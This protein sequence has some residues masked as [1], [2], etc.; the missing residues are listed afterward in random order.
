ME[1]DEN[2]P[3]CRSCGK[4]LTKFTLSWWSTL[5]FKIEEPKVGRSYSYLGQMMVVREIVKEREVSQNDRR[6]TFWLGQFGF[7]GNGHF[8]SKTCGY[9]WALRQV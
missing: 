4:F 3:Q 5:D 1:D 8:C 9:Y 6:I 2:R 7:Q